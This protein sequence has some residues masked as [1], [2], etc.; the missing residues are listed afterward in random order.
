MIRL[1]C[2]CGRKIAAPDAWLGKRVK[3]PQ[4]GKPVLVAPTDA[5]A[6]VAPAAAPP[7][8]TPEIAAPQTESPRAET[9]QVASARV[10]SPR[11]KIPEIAPSHEEPAQI[12][13]ARVEDAREDAGPPSAPT[14]RQNA[15]R[16]VPPSDTE[17]APP[18]VATQADVGEPA[19]PAPAT[20]PANP[21]GPGSATPSVQK[22]RRTP[23]VAPTPPGAA[24]ESQPVL[25]S[26]AFPDDDD[27]DFYTKQQRLPRFLGTL[28]LLIA[29]AAGASCW[30]PQLDRSS[31]FIALGGVAISTLGFGL[32]MS[33]HR[34]GL[35]MPIIGL[36]F[37]L[38]ALGLPSALPYMGKLAPAHYMAHEEEIRQKKADAEVEAQRRGLLSVVNLRLTGNKGGAAPEV[39][40]KLVNK[41]GKVIRLIQG[42]I[43]LTDRDHRPLGGL[44]MN[45]TG[46]IQPGG[47]F[48]GTNDWT[49]SEAIQ[50]AIAENKFDA[51]Y[52]ANDVVYGDGTVQTFPRP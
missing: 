28:G 21:P 23:F 19:P 30:F 6:T 41:S 22:V 7:A 17:A 31:L 24:T 1:Q 25:A 18:P 45:V 8:A 26:E 32:S 33:R 37:S 38:A 20:E 34:I 2:A 5:P 47:S 51:D 35:T 39:A 36:L 40:Y 13:P 50:S 14:R 16:S 27:D 11:V 15:K 10:E 3:C 12:E 52:R 9:P 43:Q 42:S 4:C 46:P 44:V 48:D 49:M 29:L